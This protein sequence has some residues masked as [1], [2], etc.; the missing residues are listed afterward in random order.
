MAAPI[1]IY[2]TSTGG[3]PIVKKTERAQLILSGVPAAKGRVKIVHLDI[4]QEKRD[5]VWATSGK[6]GEYP[7][8][9]VGDKFIGDIEDIEGA[10]EDELLPDLLK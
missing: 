8:I 7:L 10:N 1:Y 6:R 3:M 5:A 2:T 9:F 4:E